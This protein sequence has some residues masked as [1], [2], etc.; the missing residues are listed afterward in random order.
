MGLKLNEIFER[1]I[2]QQA[3]LLAP[4]KHT[5]RRRA[6]EDDTV[7]QHL[8]KLLRTGCQWRELDCGSASFMA[9][10]RR[11]QLWE[12]QGVIDAAYEKALKTYRQLCPP[13]RHIVDSSHVRN[14]HGTKPNTTVED[15][16]FSLL[17]DGEN[18]TDL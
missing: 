11:L 18:A 15:K 8:F 2:L 16:V 7:L 9:V 13:I 10:R 3:S 1:L 12:Q 14:R 4:P 17:Q 5:G 6:L